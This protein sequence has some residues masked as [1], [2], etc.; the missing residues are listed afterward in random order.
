MMLFKGMEI[1]N[2]R[3]S[4]HIRKAVGRSRD[5]I[6]GAVRDVWEIHVEAVVTYGRCDTRVAAARVRESGGKG[7]GE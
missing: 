2:G 4:D 7:G 3:W 5:V 6:Y 1:R